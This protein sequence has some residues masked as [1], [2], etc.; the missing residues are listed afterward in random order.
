[1]ELKPDIKI[2]LERI[3]FVERYKRLST[4]YAFDSTEC[5]KSYDN[6]EV[7][8]IFSELGYKATFDKRENFFKVVKKTPPFKFQ[9]NISLKYGLVELIWAVWKNE[10]YYGC[11]VWV[12][13]K[14]LL[15]EDEENLKDPRFRN[16]EDLKE[17]LTEAFAIYEDFKR[18]FLAIQ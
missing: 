18:E 16:Y 14:R 7:L 17:I 8:N 13:M 1:M 11:G 15:E 10:I 12:M 3:N 6:T 4:K 9:F 5:F 2:A